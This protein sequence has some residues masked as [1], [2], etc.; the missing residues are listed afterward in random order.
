VFYSWTQQ[1]VSE[2]HVNFVSEEEKQ[3]EEQVIKIREM[4]QQR[5]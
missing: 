1:C 2:E 4:E 5:E 3:A